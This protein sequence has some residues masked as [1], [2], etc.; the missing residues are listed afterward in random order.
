MPDLCFHRAW[1]THA[2]AHAKT[3]NINKFGQIV[4]GKNSTN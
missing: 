1:L 2:D 3:I 4:F